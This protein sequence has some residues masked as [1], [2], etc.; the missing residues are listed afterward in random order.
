MNPASSAASVAS[1]KIP[2]HRSRD[3]SRQARHNAAQE[4]EKAEADSESFV[5]PHLPK[6]RSSRAK[7]RNRRYFYS[8]NLKT[9]FLLRNVHKYEDNNEERYFSRSNCSSAYEDIELMPTST[10]M[11][12]TNGSEQ[13]NTRRSR[14]HHQVDTTPFPRGHDS[15]S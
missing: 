2:R 4:Q 14:H 7:R 8:K 3:R 10:N 5:R 15:V 11:S 12:S 9:Y 1:S 6:P 13:G